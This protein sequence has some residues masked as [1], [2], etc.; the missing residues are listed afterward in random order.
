MT[1]LQTQVKM[2]AISSTCLYSGSHFVR[3]KANTMLHFGGKQPLISPFSSTIG[4]HRYFFSFAGTGQ[5]SER[6][7]WPGMCR[8]LREFLKFNCFR[9]SLTILFLSQFTPPPPL[10][11]FLF[12]V[13]FFFF[14][15]DPTPT[16]LALKYP[17]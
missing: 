11:S 10:L 15:F 3:E 12:S 2:V 16:P 5:A 7:R 14:F 6:G 17:I 8:S 13:F 1:S 9:Y 4:V